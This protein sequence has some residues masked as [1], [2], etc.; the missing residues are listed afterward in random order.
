M[1]ASDRLAQ[2]PYARVKGETGMVIST[3]FMRRPS[4]GGLLRRHSSVPL[5][6]RMRTS[7]HA[8]GSGRALMAPAAFNEDSKRSANQSLTRRICFGRCAGT[9]PLS[10]GAAKVRPSPPEI[11]TGTSCL[12]QTS[13]D[14]ATRTRDGGYL[15][16][17]RD[18]M[19]GQALSLN[20][21]E[22]GSLRASP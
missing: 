14:A 21:L 20:R 7:N 10:P 6:G 15:L 9:N 17:P 18:V 22:S 4:V 8:L 16:G 3:Y 1:C 12:P 11:A 5:V 13:S 19:A 2:I